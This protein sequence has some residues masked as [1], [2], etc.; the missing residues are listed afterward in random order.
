MNE[1]FSKLRE[2]ER[3]DDLMRSGRKIIQN[4][5]EFCF[6]MDSVLIAHFPKF[7]KNFKVLDLGTGTGVIPLLAA[8]EV[9]EICAV[10]LNS[11]MAETARR[12]VELNNLSKKISVV[13]GDYR[14]HRDLFSAE[15]FDLVIANP[16]YVPIKNGETNKIHGAAAARHELTATLEDVVTAARYVLKFHGSFCMIHLA[17]RLCEIVDALH[18]HQFEM[19]R[20]QIIQPKINRDANLIMIEAVVGGKPGNLKILPP[21]VV[22]NEDNSYT[23]EIK[24]IYGLEK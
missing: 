4:K 21:L 15:S 22:H 2:G 13:E 5:S 14:L 12:N 7:K 9:A 16:P 18:R 3:L 10:E 19:K 8:D 6:S 11:R 23:D 1:D 24:K 17:A 20:L